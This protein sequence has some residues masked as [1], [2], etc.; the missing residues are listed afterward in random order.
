MVMQKRK[1]KYKE[2]RV[3]L[4]DILPYEIPITFSNRH[5]YNFLVDNKIEIEGEFVTWK[6]HDDIL[7]EI[8]RLLFDITGE[9]I[10][11]G[12]LKR[13]K[14]N[15]G[16]FYTIPFNYKIA[17]KENEFRELTLMHPANQTM[18]VNFY[19]KYKELILYHC[20]ISP[21]SIRKPHKIA[22]FFYYRIQSTNK[23]EQERR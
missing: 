16:K 18:F 8:I 11:E 12:G 14:F 13:I 22:K 1:I 17:H 21:F 15:K 9:I 7:D 23:K 3:I 10:E 2:E 19:E 20:S 5:F 6:K 4:A